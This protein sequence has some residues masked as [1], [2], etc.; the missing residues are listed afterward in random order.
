[1]RHGIFFLALVTSFLGALG[2]AALADEKAQ[3]TQGGRASVQ[4]M[5]F[6]K[7]DNT[8]VDLYVL[9]NAHG[10]TAKVMTYGAILTELDVPDRNGKLGDVVL[11]FDDLKGYLAGHP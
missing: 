10:M 3:A 4:K 1:M 2:A 5:D 7:V 11:G 6:G 9:T 8:P